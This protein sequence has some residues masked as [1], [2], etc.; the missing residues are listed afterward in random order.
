MYLRYVL[1]SPTPILLINKFKKQTKIE[2]NIGL[3]IS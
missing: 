2:Q 3:V 1:Q